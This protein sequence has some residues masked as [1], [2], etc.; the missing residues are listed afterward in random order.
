VE[1]GRRAELEAQ[2][3]DLCARGEHEKAVTLIVKQYGPELF[4]FLTGMLRGNEAHATDV[5]SL[6]CEDLW[7]G[8]PKFEQRST[9]RAWCYTLARH[10]V[11]RFQRSGPQRRARRNIPLSLASELSGLVQ[12]MTTNVS[13]R[14]ERARSRMHEMREALPLE[15][16]MLLVLRIDRE[17]DWKEVARILCDGETLDDTG[18]TRACA[19]LRKRFQSLKDQLREQAEREGLVTPRDGS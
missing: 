11:A 13:S 6:V 5:L 18:L 1:A 7:K 14:R 4:G 15:D 10:A 16:Q 12:R 17:L 3:A 9:F 8:L 19:R 2:L